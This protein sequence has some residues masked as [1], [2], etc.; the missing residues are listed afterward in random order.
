[1]RTFS[2]MPIYAIRFISR[3]FRHRLMPLPLRL[4]LRHADA[5]AMPSS[6]RYLPRRCC[7]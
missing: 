4:A 7:R 6:T 1:M 5:A 2:L 3:R